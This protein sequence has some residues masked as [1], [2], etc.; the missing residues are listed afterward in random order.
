M[1]WTESAFAIFI[2]MFLTSILLSPVLIRLAK[3]VNLLD[4]PASQK[5]KRH[6]VP[7]PLA[8][9]GVIMVSLLVLILL[10]FRSHLIINR[11]FVL[12]LVGIFAAGLWDD[13]KNMA[14]YQKLIGQMAVGII[15]IM[16]GYQVVLFGS[17]VVDYGI[18][19]I[20]FIGV[21][22]AFNFLDGS[23]GLVVGVGIIICGFLVLFSSL[24]L[25]PELQVF[26]LALVGI[27]SGL[28]FFNARPA[29]LFL[30][31]SGSQLIGLLIAVSALEYNPLG[32][33]KSTS[34]IAPILMLF[35][36]IFDVTLVVISRIRRKTPIYQGGLDHTFH[37]LVRMRFSPRQANYALYTLVFLS[38]LLALGVLYFPPSMA[39]LFFLLVILIGAGLMVYFERIL[40]NEKYDE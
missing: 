30:G 29:K 40:V 26:A 27:F 7:I 10:P 13:G 12:S 18:T 34:W 1:D 20:W 14:P 32:F 39:Y 31:D 36:P 4:Y 3:K 23:D 38:N 24:S 19:L 17:P 9:G 2:I 8:G 22:N 35:L 33:D 28:L 21:V 16:G 37:R 6:A 5:H 25:Q 11:Y 15:M